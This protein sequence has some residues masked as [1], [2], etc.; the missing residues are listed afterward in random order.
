MDGQT[1][2]N[3]KIKD[4]RRN[5]CF[6]LQGEMDKKEKAP[7]YTIGAFLVGANGLEPLTSCV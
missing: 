7:I 6:A 2:W 3:A 4:S 1:N 5:G